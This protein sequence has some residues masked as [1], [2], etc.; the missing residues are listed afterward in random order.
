LIEI[1]RDSL[2][3]RDGSWNYE[4]LIEVRGR[5]FEFRVRGENAIAL[6]NDSVSGLTTAFDFLDAQA[7]AFELRQHRRRFQQQHAIARHTANAEI[8]FRKQAAIVN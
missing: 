1:H 3:G 6:E 5:H 2:H 7:V 4:T 8:K